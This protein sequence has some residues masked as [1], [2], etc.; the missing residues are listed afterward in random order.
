M[1]I[2][3]CC[4]IYRQTFGRNSAL[5]IYDQ[6]IRWTITAQTEPAKFTS[7]STRNGGGFH[8]P[9][10]C[11][12]A[13]SSSSRPV[14]AS[15]PSANFKWSYVRMIP[16]LLSAHAVYSSYAL[17]IVAPP[18]VPGW[19]VNKQSVIVGT[20]LIASDRMETV[21]VCLRDRPPACKHASC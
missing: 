12:A 10:A 9:S 1:D 21:L 18:P 8:C 19:L 4:A 6:D 7:H 13:A 17:S 2:S 5:K 14:P 20:W 16:L 11:H 3:G 15:A